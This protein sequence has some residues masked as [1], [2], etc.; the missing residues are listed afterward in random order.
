MKEENT[1]K[2]VILLLF[3]VA[4]S[5]FSQTRSDVEKITKNYDLNKLKSLSKELKTNFAKEKQKALVMARQKGWPVK[6]M[7]AN[8]SFQELMKVTKDGYPIY[9]QTYNV[10]AAVSTRTN[11]LHNN[12]GLGLNLEGQGMTAYVWD[13]GPA[14]ITHQEYDGPGGENRYSIG[15]GSVINGNSFHGAHVAGTIMASGVDPDAKGMAP[16]AKVIGHEWTDDYAE[17]TAALPSGMLLSNHSYGF[18]SGIVPDWYFGAYIDDSRTLDEIMYNAPY[19]LHV[20]AAGND[21]NSDNLNADPLDGNSAYD[22]LTGDAT[23]KN[24][25]VVANAH[26]AT[27]D[28][29]GNLVSVDIRITSSEGPT[30]D[31]RIKPDIAGNGVG[32][33]STFEDADDHYGNIGGTSMAAP[34]VMGSLLLLQQHHNNVHGSFMKAATLKGLAL[35][36]ADDAGDNGPDAV[37]GWGLMNAKKAAETIS[38]RGL[39]SE[40]LELELSEGETYTLKIKADEVNPLIASISWT[41]VPGPENTGTANDETPVLVNDL[42]IRVTNSTDTFLPWKLTGIETNEKGDNI[43]DPFERV[44]VGV[45]T[46]EYT[47]TVSHKGTLTN[48]SQHFSLILTGVVSD[49]VIT[50]TNHTPVDACTNGGALFNFNYRQSSTTTTT[51]SA[52]NM[53]NGVTASFSSNTMD[54]DGDFTVTFENLQNLEA[55]VTYSADVVADNGNEVMRKTVQMR[56]F[57]DDFTNHPI[58]LSSPADEALGLSRLEVSLEWEEN[59]NAQSYTVEISETPSFSNL[60][61]S[62]NLADLS[63]TVTNLTPNTVYYWRVRPENSCGTNT[64]FSDIMSF[65]TEAMDCLTYTATDF[66]NA[67]VAGAAANEVAFVPFEVD[68]DNIVIENITASVTI[69]HTNV[70]D[71][72]VY[73]QSP[74]ALGPK[75]IYFVRNPCDDTDNIDATFDDNGETLAC[76]TSA[77]AISGTVK[78]EDSLLDELEG[79]NAEGTWY[80]TILDTAAD[81]G[82]SIASAS[83]EFCSFLANSYPV[84]TFTSSVIE[85]IPNSTETIT[86]NHM[87]ATTDSET[88]DQQLYTLVV[89]PANGSLTKNGNQ[90]QAGDTFT[91]ADINAGDIAYENAQIATFSD[92]FKVDILN[93][94]NGWLPNQVVSVSTTASVTNFDIGNLLIYPNPT[95]KEITVR[96]YSTSD[97]EVKVQLFDLQGREINAARYNGLI[98]MFSESMDVSNLSSGI[99]LLKA[100]QGSKTGTQK[101][102]IS[103]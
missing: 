87:Q 43:V 56:I 78:P 8:G 59:I 50:T 96:I 9:Y 76:N 17:M 72:N 27:I 30:D 48:G 83:I 101:V 55:G 22:K 4:F 24:N 52:E 26:D 67:T 2:I 14:R 103:R 7:N 49:F 91:Q 32:L 98:G 46:G 93:S 74:N 85:A 44:D 3:F 69:N 12:G 1:K 21:G 5:G 60:V 64:A 19:Y 66:S 29:E 80:L 40:I 35:H 53:P 25:L 95:D 45:G 10:D 90:M 58:I 65:Q 97:K 20:K 63:Y 42:D 38:D 89:A 6:I 73:L 41:D 71:L 79:E 102:I 37:W 51:L 13:G 47:V 34:N 92:E 88:D 70:S 31:L 15:D 77:P 100:T 62:D 99:Y 68:S 16:H 82:G 28:T 36:T 54:A 84:P 57:E 81:N 33:Y 94:G 75:T 86:A 11:W 61:A 23:S 39:Y 18:N